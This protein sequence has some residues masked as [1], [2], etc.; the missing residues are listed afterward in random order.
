[1]PHGHWFNVLIGTPHGHRPKLMSSLLVAALAHLS[2]IFRAR[3]KLQ[4]KTVRAMHLGT[5]LLT[6]TYHTA[7]FCGWI[8]VVMTQFPIPRGED[9]LALVL[10]IIPFP[11]RKSTI[12]ANSKTQRAFSAPKST[13][14]EH[15]GCRR[16]P[17][18]PSL[19]QNCSKEETHEVY[20]ELSTS[21]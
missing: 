20:G 7:P 5:I 3:S 16:R 17:L 14:G 1:M 11:Y 19:H 12:R 9:F 18:R 21:S 13:D 2:A 4:T 8:E 6:C 15:K 10:C